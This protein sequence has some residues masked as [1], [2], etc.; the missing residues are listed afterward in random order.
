MKLT[1]PKKKN[2]FHPVDGL[3]NQNRHHQSITNYYKNQ[4]GNKKM[5]INW[6]WMDN[7]Y[8]YKGLFIKKEKESD[9]WSIYQGHKV[10]DEGYKTIQKA[11]KAIDE[12]PYDIE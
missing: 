8:F 10:L 7:I 1:N 12:I 5:S 6:N 4:G 3:G 11:K 9:K 2:K